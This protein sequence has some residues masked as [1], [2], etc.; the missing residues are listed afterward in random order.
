[1]IFAH[2]IIM[3]FLFLDRNFQIPKK[4]WIAPFLHFL[5]NIRYK[6]LS[7]TYSFE[8]IWFNVISKDQISC[9]QKKTNNLLDEVILLHQVLE[10]ANL[11]KK[12]FSSFYSSQ[13]KSASISSSFFYIFSNP[14]CLAPHINELTQIFFKPVF[15]QKGWLKK[16]RSTKLGIWI[17]LLNLLMV[18]IYLK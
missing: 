8:A 15:I 10:Q 12:W 4:I 1:M 2:D 11:Q 6:I 7:I 14:M 3:T 16:K 13:N 17:S 5:Q 9:S 18:Y